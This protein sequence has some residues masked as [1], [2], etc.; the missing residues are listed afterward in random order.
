M[1]EPDLNWIKSIY[2]LNGLIF[3]FVL[4]FLYLALVMTVFG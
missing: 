2:W 3:G 4:G 1:K